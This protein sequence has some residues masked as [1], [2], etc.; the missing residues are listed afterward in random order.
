MD[1]FVKKFELSYHHKKGW[2]NGYVIIPKDHPFYGKNYDEIDNLM[3]DLDVHG[4]LTLSHPTDDLDW[5][6]LPKN[7]KGTWIVGF[8]TAH[9]YDTPE[10]WTKEA[11]IK[12]T[13][14]L[15]EQLETFYIKEK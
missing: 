10:E 6:E 12:E 14:K 2:G 9:I 1:F 11:V 4:G 5:P 7:S 8:D 3:P 15:K 13:I